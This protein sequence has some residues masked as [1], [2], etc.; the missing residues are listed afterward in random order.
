MSS[1]PT[2]AYKESHVTTADPITL[3]VMLFDGALKAVRKARIHHE[4]GNRALYAAEIQRASLIVGELLSALD[5]DQGDLPRTLSG[6]YT[7]CIQGLMDA[8][9]GNVARLDEVEKNLGTIG[10]AWRQLAKAI[11]EGEEDLA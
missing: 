3:V 4:S 8:A 5:M 11:A 7:Y 6:I 9:L 2:A 1:N 10:Q